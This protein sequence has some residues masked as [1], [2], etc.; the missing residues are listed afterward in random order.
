MAGNATVAGRN[1]KLRAE[2]QRGEEQFTEI[3]ELKQRLLDS[4]EKVIGAEQEA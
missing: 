1:K 2:V 3:E 4:E